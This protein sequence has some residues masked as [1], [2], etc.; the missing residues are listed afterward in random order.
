MTHHIALQS[1]SVRG[2][3]GPH[4]G[5]L[6]FADGDL[7]AIFTLVPKE[8]TLGEI[9]SPAGGWFLE[10]GFGPCSELMTVDP[11]VFST[12]DEAVNWVRERLMAGFAPS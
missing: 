12:L 2:D 7:V 3:G 6:V 8:E 5:R 1:V 10:A 4:E 9:H 11:P